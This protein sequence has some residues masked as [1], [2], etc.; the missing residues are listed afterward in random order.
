[1]VADHQRSLAGE[2]EVVG[3]I[4]L[5]GQREIRELRQLFEGCM[6]AGVEA[7]IRRSF[8]HSDGRRN[9]GLR[10]EKPGD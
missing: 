1:M 10:P 4:A 5:A 2:V 3:A 9:S 8:A 6:E 7:R